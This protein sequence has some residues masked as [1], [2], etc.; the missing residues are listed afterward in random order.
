MEVG[1]FQLNE[2]YQKEDT[3]EGTSIYFE[4]NKQNMDLDF[5]FNK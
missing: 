3:F 4:N 2:N 1:A 5:F